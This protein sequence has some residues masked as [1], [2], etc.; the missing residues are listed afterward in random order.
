MIYRRTF[1][2]EIIHR[3]NVVD[4]VGVERVS[5]TGA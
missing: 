4:V 2:L 1:Q 3:T 5:H